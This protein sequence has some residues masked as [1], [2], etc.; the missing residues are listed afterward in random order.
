MAKPLKIKD[1]N[2]I[3][4]NELTKSG[5]FFYPSVECGPI[6]NEKAK[7][8]LN[9][10]STDFEQAIKETVQFFQK[11]MDFYAENKKATAKYHLAISIKPI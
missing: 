2:L 5:K 4:E 9:F 6:S 11:S 8:L 10:E 7:K 3:D 1:L